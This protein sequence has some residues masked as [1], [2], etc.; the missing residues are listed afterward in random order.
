[1]PFN[2]TQGL[3]PEDFDFLRLHRPDSPD[4]EISKIIGDILATGGKP[5]NTTG[6]ILVAPAN[7]R[8]ISI[9]ILNYSSSAS[10]IIWIV[11]SDT[12]NQGDGYPLRQYDSYEFNLDNPYRGE[13]WA[14]ASGVA[15][16]VAFMEVT[17]SL[18]LM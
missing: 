2:D 13:I 11:G 12:V 16:T 4:P 8:R 17:R 1:M 15:G 14:I 6:A 5:V 7:D 9:N 18:P 3:K 10:A